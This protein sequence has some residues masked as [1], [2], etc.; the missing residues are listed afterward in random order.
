VL[1]A[2]LMKIACVIVARAAPLAVLFAAHVACG[3]SS[4]AAGPDA[5]AHAPAAKGGGVCCPYSTSCSCLGGGGW[6]PTAGQCSNPTTLCAADG[7]WGFQMDGHGCLIVTTGL[8]D[9]CC[10]CFDAGGAHH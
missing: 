1:H 7:P 10:G 5:I 8:P 2:E 9:H 4:T 3:S 6:A